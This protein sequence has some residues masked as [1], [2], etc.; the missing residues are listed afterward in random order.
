MDEGTDLR[1]RSGMSLGAYAGQS[2]DPGAG[3]VAAKPGRP[4]ITTTGH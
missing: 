2:C 3:E 1:Q 4:T